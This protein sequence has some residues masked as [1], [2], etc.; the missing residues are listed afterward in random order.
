MHRKERG[1]GKI[2]PPMDCPCVRVILMRIVF[3]GEQLDFVMVHGTTQPFY[4][5]KIL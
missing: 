2:S 3:D 1:D 4:T 5:S